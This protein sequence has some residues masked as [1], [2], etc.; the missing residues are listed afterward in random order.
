MALE[1]GRKFLVRSEVW[2]SHVTHREQI[3]DGLLAKFGDGKVRIR[4]TDQRATITVKGPRTGFT[5][6][7]FE[8]DIARADAEAMLSTMCGLTSFKTRSFVPHDGLVWI[9]DEY[10][11]AGGHSVT[12]AEIELQSEGQIFGL[13]EWVGREVTLEPSYRKANIQRLLMANEPIRMG[14]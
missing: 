2:R 14:A 12:L 4:L 10:R 5:R 9:V 1:I 13:P 7:E 3:H 11:A 6:P 8:Y